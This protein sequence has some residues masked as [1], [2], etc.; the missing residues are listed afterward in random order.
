MR[1]AE[2][3]IIFV[4]REAGV[5]KI[6][7]NEVYKTLGTLGRLRFPVLP[8][9]GISR[10]STRYGEPSVLVLGVMMCVGSFWLLRRR[11]SG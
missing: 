2:M 3:P 9:N 5:S 11:K 8:W 10:L 4:D 6:N 1:V 7:R